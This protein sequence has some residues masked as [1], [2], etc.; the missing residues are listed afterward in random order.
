MLEPSSDR[1]LLE[2]VAADDPSDLEILYDRYG[3]LAFGLALRLTG[4][5]C[6]A[7]AAV[8]DTFI[9]IWREAPRRESLEGDIREW[10]CAIVRNRS[11]SILRGE[12]R[13]S[14]LPR[15]P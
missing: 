9:E 13:C 2:R 8:L 6:L 11:I 10:I 12:P 5:P 14:P 3:S 7:E 1:A 4:E 15:L